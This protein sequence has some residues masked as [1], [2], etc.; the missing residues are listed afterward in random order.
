VK[1]EFEKR[2]RAFRDN[3]FRLKALTDQQSTLVSNVMNTLVDEVRK[4]LLEKPTELNVPVI[5]IPKHKFE[6]WFGDE[7][8]EEVKV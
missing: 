7:E 8:A 6:K 3:S 1:G 5:W 4:D 2:I